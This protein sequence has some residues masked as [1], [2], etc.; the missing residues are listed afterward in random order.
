MEGEFDLVTEGDSKVPVRKQ[1]KY[2]CALDEVIVTED[3]QEALQNLKTTFNGHGLM[4]VQEQNQ[5]P[6]CPPKLGELEAIW[7]HEG[8]AVYLIR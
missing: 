4:I 6:P 7:D 3:A 2:E 8:D 1:R 5:A